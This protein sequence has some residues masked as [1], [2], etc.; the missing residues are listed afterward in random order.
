MVV[1]QVDFYRRPLRDAGGE[2]LWELA[3][4]SPS[5]GFTHTTS[6]LQSQANVRW[7]ADRLQEVAA[8]LPD[9]LQVFRPQCLS[10][11]EAAGKALGIPVDA[12]R[13]LPQL[14]QFLRDRV[15]VYQQMPEFSGESYDP[16]ALEKP[17][18]LPLPEELQGDRWQF[19][20]VSAGDLLLFGDRPIPVKSVPEFLFPLRLGLASTQSIPGVIIYGGRRSMPLARWLADAQPVSLNY[21]SGDPDGLILEMGLVD[22]A[23]VATFDDPEVKVAAQTYQKRQQKAKGL[24]FLLVQPDDSGMTY[25]GLWLLQPA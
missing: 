4:Y 23:I 20:S 24:H 2:P 11:L 14:K 15:K 16:I 7:L 12:T 22:R 25:S 13:R 17:P 6:C 19:A 9:R 1:W 18:P 3:I 8:S 10:L 5:D 21:I